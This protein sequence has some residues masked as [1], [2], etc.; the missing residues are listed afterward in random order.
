MQLDELVISS[1]KSNLQFDVIFN[2]LKNESYWGKDKTIE[3]VKTSIENSVCF[4]IYKGEK[5]IGFTRVVTDI[6]VFAY[7]CDV[8]ILPEFQGQGIGKY[9]LK[10]ILEDK[11]FSGI[12]TWFLVTDDAQKF[13][14]KFG[15]VEIPSPSRF[16]V[17][18]ESKIVM[19]E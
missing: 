1:D 9:L 12:G 3:I 11:M 7:L 5:Q 13:Y 17:K 14:N 6:S 16:L 8:F 19:S 10:N 18:S 2:Y 4:G 15:F